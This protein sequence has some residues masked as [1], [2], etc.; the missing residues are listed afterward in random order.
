MSIPMNIAEGCGRNSDPELARFLK[1][2]L[3]SAAEVEYQVLLCQEL[4]YLE[5]ENA[6]RLARELDEIKRML[7]RLIHRLT[8]KIERGPHPSDS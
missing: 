2:A 8:P 7:A 3:G 5:L 6:E 1:I 4:H